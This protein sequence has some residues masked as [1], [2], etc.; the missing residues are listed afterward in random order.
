ME[1]ASYTD[2]SIYD[3]ILTTNS[4]CETHMKQQ[5]LQ[6]QDFEIALASVFLRIMNLDGFCAL[7]KRRHCPLEKLQGL[8][9]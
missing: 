4:I 5:G 2:G 8:I 1:R 6:F 3:Q 9:G 7:N